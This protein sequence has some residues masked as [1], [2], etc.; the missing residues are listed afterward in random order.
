MSEYFI[1]FFVSNIGNQYQSELITF[2]FKQSKHGGFFFGGLFWFKL[3]CS[4]QSVQTKKRE[5][6]RGVKNMSRFI[7]NL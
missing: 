2:F 1:L 7:F 3:F 6:R 5:E 4:D